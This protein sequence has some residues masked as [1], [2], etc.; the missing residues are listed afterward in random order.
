M[1]LTI[2]PL[3]LGSE[4][5]VRPG[6]DVLMAV[7]GARQAASPTARRV[8]A[9]PAQGRDGDAEEAR[10]ALL[11]KGRVGSGTVAAKVARFAEV[12]AI[13][14]S[15]TAVGDEVAI[16]MNGLFTRAFQAM[17]KHPDVERSNKAGRMG[18]SGPGME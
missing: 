8:A 18:D 3:G 4:S 2:H 12:A 14:G 16:E 11:C 5:V 1:K 6:F 13:P 17:V 15:D 10:R 9:A 7:T